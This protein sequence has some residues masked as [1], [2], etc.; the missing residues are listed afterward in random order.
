MGSSVVSDVYGNLP[1]VVLNF[2]FFFIGDCCGDCID[3]CCGDSCEVGLFGAWYIIDVIFLSGTIIFSGVIEDTDA[4]S[5]S[6]Y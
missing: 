2:I 3:D 4:F 6:S 5:L 1:I